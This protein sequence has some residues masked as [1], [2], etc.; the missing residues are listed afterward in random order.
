MKTLHLPPHWQLHGVEAVL[1][2]VAAGVFVRIVNRIIGGL[3]SA[4]TPEDEMR[5]AR[6]ATFYRLLTSL[7]RYV[8]DFAA[9]IT[10]LD[11]FGVPTASLLAGAGI[12]GLAIGFGAQGLVQDVVTGLFL[13]YEDQYAVGDQISLPNLSLTGTVLELGIRI[14]RLAGPTGEETVVPNRLVLEVQNHTRRPTSVTVNIPLDPSASPDRARQVF[15]EMVAEVAHEVPGTKLVGVVDIQPA[16]VV[17]AVS[18]PVRYANAYQLG[19]QLREAV[20]KALYQSS[21]PLAGVVKG[22]GWTSPSM[23]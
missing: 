16:A 10:V 2:I 22:T 8:V 13:L 1:I 20:A 12:V 6:R 21:V 14:T 7:V 19:C 15:E 3:E 11:L 5:R 4:R 18:A 9:I 17:W 23:K